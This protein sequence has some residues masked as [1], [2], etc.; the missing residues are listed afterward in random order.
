MSKHTLCYF[1]QTL[2]FPNRGKTKTISKHDSAS[3]YKLNRFSTYSCE[4]P[5]LIGQL[6]HAVKSGIILVHRYH[7]HGCATAPV[8]PVNLCQIV[9]NGSS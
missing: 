7:K 5:Y 6:D 4:L 9:K 1:D 3:V 2:L 8:T